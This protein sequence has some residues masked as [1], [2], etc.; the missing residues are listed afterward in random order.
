MGCV[1]WGA[2]LFALTESSL[3]EML[4]FNVTMQYSVLHSYS[5]LQCLLP[6]PYVPATSELVGE[7]LQYRRQC[8]QCGADY[9]CLRGP[10]IVLSP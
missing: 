6:S 1:L 7:I 8:A 2:I 3:R 4:E 5:S 10:V 9:K